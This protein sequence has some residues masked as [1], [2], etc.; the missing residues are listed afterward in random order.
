MTKKD[1]FGII[2][3]SAW[4]VIWG[5]I[6][7]VI[8]LPLLNRE[9]YVAGSIGQLATFVITAVVSLFIGIWLFPK[10][11]KNSFVV[12]ALGLDSDDTK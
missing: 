4:V 9:I 10:V 5:S 12:A 2:Y 3:V 1:W 6:G 7:S 8:D 11:S